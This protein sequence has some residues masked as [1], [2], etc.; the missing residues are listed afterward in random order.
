MAEG[1]GLYPNLLG[2]GPSNPSGWCGKANLGALS[3]VFGGARPVEK[4]LCAETRHVVEH[5][6]PRTLNT[7]W[8][9]QLGQVIRPR[10]RVCSEFKLKYDLIDFHRVHHILLRDISMGSEISNNSQCIKPF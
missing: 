1:K 6:L 4:G 2:G 7:P 10:S 9:E 5:G 8:V 3:Q